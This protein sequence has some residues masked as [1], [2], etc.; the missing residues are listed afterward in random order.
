[1]ESLYGFEMNGVDKRRREDNNR[2]DIKMLWQRNHEILGLALSGLTQKEI[3]E[4]LDI[5]S[6]TVSSTVNSTLGKKKLAEMRKERDGEYIDVSKRIAELAEKAIEVYEEIFDN[7]TVSY[8]LKKKTSDTVLMD[9]GGHRAP[10]QIATR[11]YNI[12]A[13]MEELEEFKKLGYEAAKDAG[14]LVD[15]PENDYRVVDE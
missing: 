8:N 2:Q 12:N 4:R 15:I 13:T 5:A 3:A 7:P 14:F 6:I 11:S 10:T 1:M 9:L